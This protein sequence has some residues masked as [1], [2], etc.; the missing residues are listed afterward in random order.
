MWHEL[1]HDTYANGHKY[2]GDFAICMWQYY[3]HV[4]MCPWL[5]VAVD[6][7][8]NMHRTLLTAWGVCC[9]YTSSFL[10]VIDIRPGWLADVLVV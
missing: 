1:A 6:L 5:H 7:V 3:R 8:V 9:Q 2:Y 10:H 4:C